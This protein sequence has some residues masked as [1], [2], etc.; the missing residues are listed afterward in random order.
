MAKE[1]EIRFNISVEKLI[2][3]NSFHSRF[4]LKV[5]SYVYDQQDEELEGVI[6]E[7]R[8]SLDKN[9]NVYLLTDIQYVNILNNFYY[10][11]IKEA[12]RL[13]IN[14]CTFSLSKNKE[15]GFYR[16]TFIR[17]IDDIYTFICSSEER[18][19]LLGTIINP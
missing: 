14:G 16:F 6:V 10:Y 8:D 1:I 9:P 15:S 18:D 12:K 19:Y 5:V 3:L 7:E 11:D 4:G 2:E 13:I 17:A